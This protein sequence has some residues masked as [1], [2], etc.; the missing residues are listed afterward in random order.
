MAAARERQK[1]KRAERRAAAHATK[2][3]S[4]LTPQDVYR[5]TG[6]KY[7]LH[8]KESLQ[9]HLSF[10]AKPR[11]GSSEA[12]T[13]QKQE[14]AE[15]DSEH[16]HLGQDSREAEDRGQVEAQP[17]EKMPPE[18]QDSGAGRRCEVTW[19]RAMAKADSEMR[20]EFPEAGQRQQEQW[21]YVLYA[22]EQEHKAQR[23]YRKMMRRN[24]K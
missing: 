11:A 10:L 16:A 3:G 13:E 1:A 22:R 20:A 7:T 19:S 23:I 24:K 9:Q 2:T 12:S 4:Q 6:G 14:S 15:C 17:S 5:L 8:T 21:V 18:L